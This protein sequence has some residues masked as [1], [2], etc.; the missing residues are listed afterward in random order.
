MYSWTSG[1]EGGVVFNVFL[2]EIQFRIKETSRDTGIL[3]WEVALP[4]MSS[5]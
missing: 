4:Y 2:F 5:L 1:F 3:A